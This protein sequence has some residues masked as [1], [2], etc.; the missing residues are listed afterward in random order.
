MT[1]FLKKN[2]TTR[3]LIDSHHPG[4]VAARAC[5][6][7]SGNVE[8]PLCICRLCPKTQV[9]LQIYMLIVVLRKVT[10]F[11]PNQSLAFHGAHLHLVTDQY[12]SGAKWTFVTKKRS[13]A[14]TNHGSTSHCLQAIFPLIFNI[15]HNIPTKTLVI[16]SNI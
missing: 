6:S 8:R 11:D 4:V 14:L 2:Q 3:S 16:G 12:W 10:F 1:S 7:P 13:L 5:G 9:N 15:K